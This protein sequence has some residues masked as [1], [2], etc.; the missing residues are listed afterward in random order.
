MTIISYY[1]NIASPI[2]TPIP[3]RDFLANC[4]TKALWRPQIEALRL[5]ATDPERAR[6]KKRL[7][8]VTLSARYDGRRRAESLKTIN[9]YIC[10]DIDAKDNPMLTTADM[11]QLAHNTG[12]SLATLT[13]CSGRGVFCICPVRDLRYVQD[14]FLSLRQYFASQGLTIDKACRDTGRLRYVT[15]DPDP[16]FNAMA[17]PLDDRIFDLVQQHRANTWHNTSQIIDHTSRRHHTQCAD[18]DT[19]IVDSVYD[20][21][22]RRSYRFT[23]IVD[24]YDDWIRLGFAC[25]SQGE[26]ARKIFTLL[27]SLSAGYDPRKINSQYDSFLRDY[28]PSRAGFTH[29]L[30]LIKKHY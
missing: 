8:A 30:A 15:Y 22:L 2:P 11:K 10:I 9:P 5:A 4:T 26:K 24:R 7:P 25:A 13:S 28:S 1:D 19:D 17:A 16:R 14:N 6:R 29:I 18:T 21:L 20:T 27:S 12:A 3:M 23:G